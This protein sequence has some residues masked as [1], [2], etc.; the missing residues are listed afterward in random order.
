MNKVGFTG[1]QEPISDYQ[2]MDL[3]NMVRNIGLSEGHH[4]DCVNA[5]AEFHKIIAQFGWRKIVHPGPSTTL[6]AYCEG[7]LVL[8]VKPNLERNRDIVDETSM[9]IACPKGPEEQ[10]SG[11]W[12]TIRYARRLCRPIHI[13]M[14]DG[15]HLFECAVGDLV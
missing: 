7:D 5:D 10:R 1:T 11:T 9:L 15:K 6:R 3:T 4:G 14:P 2:R 8:P 13:L 12:S